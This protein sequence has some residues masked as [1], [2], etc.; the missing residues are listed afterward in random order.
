MKKIIIILSALSLPA[1]L[2]SCSSS[3]PT[4]EYPYDFVGL[5]DDIT[6]QHIEIGDSKHKVEKIFGSSEHSGN[7]YVFQYDDALSISYDD[8]NNVDWIKVFH[9]SRDNDHNR[10]ELPNGINTESIVTDLTDSFPYVYEISGE[11][12]NETVTYVEGTP[13]GY[14]SLS[15]EYL[16]E[17]QTEYEDIQNDDSLTDEEK[18]E[19]LDAQNPIYKMSIKYA[20][21]DDIYYIEVD[22]LHEWNFK[23]ENEKL[24]S[25]PPEPA[26]DIKEG[27]II[28]SGSDL[29]GKTVR[30]SGYVDL[31]GPHNYNEKNGYVTYYLS[32]SDSE[33]I[34][35]NYSGY[36]AKTIA[37][38]IF[39]ILEAEGVVTEIYKAGETIM[40]ISSQSM[41]K[42]GVAP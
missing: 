15:K 2:A 32:L 16:Y 9:S 1:A 39:D 3:A 40:Q 37:Y 34:Q 38:D 28:S 25:E 12:L 10:Y 8:D 27:D 7:S 22:A 36:D 23:T 26:I 5:Y 18:D 31:Y 30:V 41:K 17:K 11:F 6:R 4:A 33:R 35:V 13:D 29:V 20:S 21:Y 14:I 24:S 42:T 19:F